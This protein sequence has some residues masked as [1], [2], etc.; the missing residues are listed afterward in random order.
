MENLKTFW[1]FIKST[2][3]SGIIFSIPLAIV[4]FLLLKVIK[5]IIEYTE[6]F[7][8][9]LGIQ[10]IFGRFTMIIVVIVLIFFIFFLAGLLLKLRFARLIHNNVDLFALKYI[11][12]YDK[13]IS[14]SKMVIDE[15]LNRKNNLYDSWQCYLIK[16]SQYWRL[17]FLINNKSEKITLFYPASPDPMSG[18]VRFISRTDFESLEKIAVE[19][20][21]AI[22]HMKK[23]GDGIAELFSKQ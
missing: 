23:Y 10:T 1:N 6:P 18:N 4:L 8:K 15:K 13:I 14:Q 2:I 16:T 7:V 3:Y 12:G 20:G 5:S 21:E 17:V 19:T 9:S 22:T 11:P